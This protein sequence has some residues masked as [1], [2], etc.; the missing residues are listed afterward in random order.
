MTGTV[1]IATLTAIAI[2]RYNVVVYPLNPL[3]STTNLRSKLMVLF[4]WL[5]GL[6]FS[7]IPLLDIGLS[8]YVPE[9]YLTACSFDYLTTDSN[10]RIFMFTYFCFAWV[11]PFV[12][13]TYCY[14]NILKVVVTASKIQSSKEKNKTEI[15]LAGVVV[16]LIGLWFM[17]WTP[18]A[19][20]ALL[21]I[22]G[23]MHLLSPL[24]SMIPAIFAK[25]AACIDPY[26]Y[27]VNHPRYRQELKRMFCSEQNLGNSQFA[28]SHY[29]KGGGGG[30]G[31]RDAS[32]DME[33]VEF[34]G[35][36]NNATG[37]RRGPLER[38]ASSIC[39]ESE[40]SFSGD[41]NNK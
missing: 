35:N 24:G 20:V 27:A 23:N 26:L 32:E 14:T 15:K 5:Y 33:T 40:L 2:D 22:S 34:G 7:T 41:Y 10:A 21:G 16:G 31:V 29:A 9:G 13:I 30:R 6:F 28:T 39:E 37:P 19:I 11:L 12:I 3:R 17:A 1:S 38:G 36:K 4:V 8:S 25:S 18:Y